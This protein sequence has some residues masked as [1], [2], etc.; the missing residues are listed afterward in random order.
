MA[1]K[2][3]ADENIPFAREAF[4]CLG[5][6]TLAKGRAI[7]HDMVREADA[8][9]VRSV[10][11]VNAAL[12]DGTS[13]KFVATATI[14]VDHID[15]GYLSE[16]G[17]GFAAA[18]GSNANSVAE[19]VVAALLVL[20]HRG[21]F[22][23]EGK[24]IGVVGVG[25][26]G[27]RVVEK[28]RALGMHVL[29]NDPP[30]QRQ[31][32]DPRFL[33]LS[34]LL[35]ADILTFHVPLTKEGP[36]ATHHMISADLLSRFNVGTILINTS[37]GAVA[38]TAALVEAA[39]S[40]RLGGL[41]LDVF[42]REPNIPPA[43]VEKADLA[44]PHIAGYSYDGKVAGTMMVY[45]AACEFFGR[46]VQWDAAAAMPPPQHPRL[47]PL[48]DIHPSQPSLSP[49]DEDILRQLVLTLYNIEADDAQLRK[50]LDLPAEQRGA[51]F[52]S[53]RKTY[54][55]RREFHNTRVETAGL[56]DSL[57]AKIA[58]LGFRV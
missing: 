49:A 35:E 40:G 8:L 3:I 42:E 11:K 57:R 33:P 51:Y 21:G 25:N 20:A 46:P 9:F 18:P 56:P 28:C 44:T 16:R 53:L 12:L 58:G 4:G 10:T 52:D 43:L 31:T 29:Q 38:D 1:M 26:V 32:G 17:I 23:L 45:R 30:L 22:R 15:L 5:E 6:V 48:A 34:A 47:N 24:T 27:R 14:G 7:T 2:I 41:V 39:D 50:M 55:V 13:V 37:R 54:P 19:Y 36:D